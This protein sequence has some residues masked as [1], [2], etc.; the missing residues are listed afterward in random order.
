[1]AQREQTIV[2]KEPKLLIVE[3]KDDK[4]F[5]ES[6]ITFFKIPSIQVFSVNGKSNFKPKLH[7]IIQS[8]GFHELIS[9][10]GIIRD[11]DDN[12]QNSFKSI[13][14]TLRKEKLPT[15]SR[16]ME[17]TAGKP[18]IQIIILPN[19]RDN[20]MLEDIC[21]QSIAQ[22]S[23][24]CIEEYISCMQGCNEL[25]SKN[26]S[27]TKVYTYLAAQEDPRADLGVS[28]AQNSW[29]FDHQAFAEIR[30]FLQKL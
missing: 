16:L 20:G 13:Q 21:L 15:P 1:M 5:F 27:K 22:N 30:K 23:I 7:A 3:G 10:I 24:K 29:N 2:F 18:S 8:P 19:N 11:A 26:L 4:L 6:M 9:D 28:A 17:K 25:L 12:C 14:G